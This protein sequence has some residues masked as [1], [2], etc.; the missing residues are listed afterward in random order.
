MPDTNY[1][2]IVI[3]AGPAGENAADIA[4]RH[5]LRTAIVER[6]LVGGECSYWACMPSKALLRPVEVAHAAA[7]TPGYSGGSID[8]DEAL[9]RRDRMSANW[10]DS[11]QVEWLEGADVDLIRGHG[12]I[13]GERRIEVETEAGVE[14]YEVTRAVVLATGTSASF[15][16]I[17]GLEEV[18]VWDNRD[19]TT[20]KEVPRRLLVIGSGAVGV[21]MAQAWKNLGAEEVT[22]VE[23]F[24]RILIRE[25][26]EASADLARALEEDGIRILTGINTERLERTGTDGP[27]T[28]LL[29][30]SDDSTS[31]VEA[32]EVLI[33]TGRK[34]N[35]ADLGLETV[36]LTPGKFVEVDE[37]MRATGIDGDWLYAVGDINGRTLLTHT[38]KYQARVA[39]AHIAGVDT[40]AWGDL[41]GM[42]RVVFTV[43]KVTAAGL[44]EKEAVEAGLDVRTVTY[45]IGHVAG[46]A[47]LGRGYRGTAKLVVDAE[48]NVL[49][50]AT[51]VDPTAGDLIHS[52]TVA[53]VGELTLDVLWHAIPAFPAV[54]EVWLRLLEAYRD[55]YNHEFR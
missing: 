18:G 27:V 16:P 19:A 32:D 25:E 20:A 42:P 30:H 7:R 43:P 29:R 4:A 55:R 31:R 40:R 6:E 15:P 33:A 12:R 35:T 21:E 2:V 49:V 23:L 1:D 10:D 13:N 45:D 34:P 48:R 14:E 24:D 22:L 28:A 53:I 39:G 5:G 46:T 38:G 41:K 9:T 17:E 8:V 11:G 47:T 52:A 54:A 50:G 37:H 51:F 26:P 36:G 44:T 3:G